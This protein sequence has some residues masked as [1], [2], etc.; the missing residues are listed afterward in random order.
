MTRQSPASKKHSTDQLCTYT[1]I[2]VFFKYAICIKA[3]N[4][5]LHIKSARTNKFLIKKER[6]PNAESA[7]LHKI[8]DDIYI[9]ITGIDKDLGI[10]VELYYRKGI[11]IIWLSFFILILS[12]FVKKNLVEIKSDNSQ[13]IIATLI[14]HL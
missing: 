9:V 10:A 3:S 14:H 4:T 8:F 11:Q 5:V 12:C 2:S 7:I 13:L 6:L 1:L